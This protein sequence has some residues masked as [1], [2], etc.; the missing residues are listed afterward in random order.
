MLKGILF[1]AGFALL[2]HFEIIQLVLTFAGI[3]IAWFGTLLMALGG[4]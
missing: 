1:L 2:W 3:A 4:M